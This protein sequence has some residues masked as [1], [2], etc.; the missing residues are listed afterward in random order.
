LKS[1]YDKKRKREENMKKYLITLTLIC[2]L[3]LLP[4]NAYAS[5]KI[6][7][8]GN[9]IIEER[10]DGEYTIL[11]APDTGEQDENSGS[12]DPVTPEEK[13]L[14]EDKNDRTVSSDDLIDDSSNG[15][16]QD[17][18]YSTT[19]IQEDAELYASSENEKDDNMLL[20]IISSIIGLSIGSIGTY[21]FLIKRK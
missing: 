3:A 15:N 19:A 12:V 4:S 7:E 16:H 6:D 5:V 10:K 13:L 21:L 14:L 17:D 20:V 9:T 18:I 1:K 11:V 8:D 2:M